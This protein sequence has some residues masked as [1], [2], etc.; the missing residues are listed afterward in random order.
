MAS[1]E[2]DNTKHKIITYKPKFYA[3]FPAES[4]ALSCTVINKFL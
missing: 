2:S 3:P 4:T 1:S